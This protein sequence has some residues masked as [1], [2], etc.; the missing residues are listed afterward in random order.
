MIKNSDL[1]GDL[2]IVNIM[3]LR[4]VRSRK[5]IGSILSLLTLFIFSLIC[6]WFIN[7]KLLF[8]YKEE[9]EI[10]YATHLFII[11][12]HGEKEI[13]K[14]KRNKISNCIYFKYRHIEYYFEENKFHPLDTGYVDKD[15]LLKNVNP[16]SERQVFELNKTFGNCEVIVPIPSIT[17]FFQNELTSP[18]Y[19][20]QYTSL[21]VF[22]L[23]GFYQ[24]AILQPIIAL[25]TSLINYLILR[26]AMQQLKKKAENH[27]QI[28]VFRQNISGKE[29]CITVNSIELVP[30][31]IVQIFCNQIL[32]CD[33]LIL[34]GDVLVDEQSLTGESIPVQKEQIKQD[35]LSNFNYQTYKKSILFD[36][37]KVLDVKNTVKVLVL[38]TGYLSYK[39]QIFRNALYPKPPKIM[40]FIDAVKFL[41]IIAVLIIGLYFGLLWKM[42][43]LD[44]DP[45]LIALR[46]GDAIVWILP[47]NLVTVVN[48]TM[49]ATLSRLKLNNILGTQP[50]KTLEASQT[51]IICFDKTGTLT[52][53]KIKVKYVFD[54]K[55]NKIQSISDK[56]LLQSLMSCCH[57]CY[58]LDNQLIGDTLDIAMIY[59]SNLNIHQD[60]DYKFKVIINGNG[61]D[62][63]SKEI[64]FRI[65]KIFE[66]SSD[67]QRMGVIAMSD[68]IIREDQQ[69]Q[70][71]DQED[72]I[73][74]NQYYYFSKGSAEKI[75]SLCISVPEG[76]KDMI[77]QESLKGMRIISTGYKRIELQ[78]IVKSQIELE[79]RLKYLGS[80][81]FENELKLNTKQTIDELK[82]AQ[83]KL[84]ILSGDHILSCINCGIESGII[85]FQKF[86]ILI[87]FDIDQNDLILEEL[88][89]YQIEELEGK[90]INQSSYELLQSLLPS[91]LYVNS[92]YESKTNQNYQWAMSGQAF[93]YL[94]NKKIIY[95]LIQSCQIF[96]RMSP[97]QKS[98]VIKILQEQKLHVCMIGDGSN[99]CHALKQSNIGISFQQCDAA[100]TA[101][102]VNTNDSIDC[103]REVL[104]QSKA[105]SCNVME[106]FK[107][108]M[109]IN[110]SKYVSAQL[111]MYQMQNFNNE[112]LL[113]LNYLSNIPIVAMQTLTPPSSKLT[114]D[115]INT[116]M[117]SLSNFIP[118]L[119]ILI[120]SGLNMLGSYLILYYQEWYLPYDKNEND[121][122]YFF[123]GDMNTQ[124]FINMNIYF[125]LSF[126]SINTYAP[127]KIPFW[128]QYHL[129][130]PILLF[131]ILAILI[132]FV[133]IEF[134]DQFLGL[135][136]IKLN[137]QYQLNQYYFNITF[138]II[139]M[140]QIIYILIMIINKTQSNLNNINFND[141]I[142]PIKSQHPSRRVQVLENGKAIQL[143]QS[144]QKIPQIITE[145]HSPII[146]NS[147]KLR[148]DSNYSFQQT[149]QLNEKESK[150]MKMDSENV[151]SK[152]KQINPQSSLPQIPLSTMNTQTKL[153]DL[154]RSNNM[155]QS[156]KN[157]D[158][159]RSLV[160]SQFKTNSN[161]QKQ[162]IINNSTTTGSS[163]DSSCNQSN[164][165]YQ[166]CA[167]NIIYSYCGK[168]R[169]RK[170]NVSA[171]S[172]IV[173]DCIENRI[174]SQ[175][176][177]NKRMEIA[178]LTKIMTFYITM[179]ILEQLN[180]NFKDIRVKVTKKAS[181]TI[182]TTA[183]LKYNDI[184]TI[185]DL[186]YGL[187]LPSG[188]DAATLIAQAIGT[189]ILFN[190]ADKYLDC[191]LLDIE[192]MSA[193]GYYYNVQLKTHQ[194]PIEIFIN[195]MNHYSN[196]IGQQNT[197]FACVHGLANED[198]YSSCYD[199]VLLS[200]EC[201]RYDIFHQVISCK[202]YISKSINNSKYYEWKNTN[203]LLEKGFFG[204]KTGVTDS[205]GP[206]LASAYRSN[207]MEYYII[208]VLSCKNL[209]L[210]F[211][212]TI[213]FL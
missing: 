82:K 39:G 85:E 118:I 199:I 50:D 107:Y 163:K 49:T 177:S 60:N 15:F 208:I 88:S 66:F 104:L 175:R 59:Y 13:Q 38:R 14:V 168:P 68:Q 135:T 183:E 192:Q 116:S 81:I 190:E 155:V 3:P 105:T 112:E 56:K 173:Y 79:Q 213:S 161:N 17:S 209:Q 125:L 100:L 83:L 111:M 176:K 69:I 189:I 167:K 195:K 121:S 84:K 33:C 185:Q 32:P 37:T 35:F 159:K 180:L 87:D 206:C 194:C 77:T 141:I 108:Y 74:Q 182:G 115:K 143:L 40:F 76:F 113:Y 152:F 63:R 144:Y 54:E 102:F 123:Q 10:L 139:S 75:S 29:E 1:E 188:N 18:L 128:K 124:Q 8:Y 22:M 44:Y 151:T 138:S 93:E 146:V 170:V 165:Q 122:R 27:Q 129:N 9:K 53:N 137:G 51:E 26:R 7:L 156:P 140:D 149:Q 45:T 98:E 36:G 120:F 31:D 191:T 211:D 11:N 21:T 179:V 160:R 205:A 12:L 6:R 89:H 134:I 164:Q 5:I 201:L 207:E 193:E 154:T 20:T 64:T 16:L 109:I 142:I 153:N 197:Q 172:F 30:G 212:E 86:T 19:F 91:S 99:D 70:L 171:K 169:K 72:I 61:S 24:L 186:L 55:N 95:E 80:I 92:I 110:V 106:I 47:P 23:E 145:F 28:T 150:S 90:S 119:I 94:R 204:I 103:I 131:L 203:K 127:F 46:L 52:T 184:L 132:Q 73:I 157:S 202:E 166:I 97:T 178:S 158:T 2:M 71:T 133:S 48:L 162:N 4:I 101:S 62:Q 198:N 117:I 41:V 136:E 187:M 43:L 65:I 58:L 130:I 34:T 96:G 78:D 200:Q 42:I 181:E 210:R 25:L 67:L 147:I 114:K 174:V 196:L 126:Y 57:Q 148:K